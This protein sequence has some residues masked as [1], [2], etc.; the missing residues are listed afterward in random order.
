M[1]GGC[2]GAGPGLGGLGM[3]MPV[4][5]L[6]GWPPSAAWICWNQRRQGSVSCSCRPSRNW[7]VV[8]GS[9]ATISE[10]HTGQEIDYSDHDAAR[11]ARGEI[12]PESAPW[13]D[14]RPWLDPREDMRREFA[15]GRAPGALVDVFFRKP[16][17]ADEY[18]RI[19]Q[20]VGQM[21]V[22]ALDRR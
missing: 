21:Q 11:D 12:G 9:G 19:V 7:T 16:H 1:G 2:G 22:R 17:D 20:I 18:V 14:L 6:V 8:L 3:T 5:A 10:P 15:D 13:L 4:S